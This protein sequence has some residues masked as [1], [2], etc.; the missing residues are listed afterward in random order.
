MQN[1]ICLLFASGRF[2]KL[3]LQTEK[4]DIFYAGTATGE[5]GSQ[6]T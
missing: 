4:M 6:L 1:E 5:Q 2:V 3:N